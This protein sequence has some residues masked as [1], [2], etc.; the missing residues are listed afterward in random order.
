MKPE[1]RMF[2]LKDCI[3]NPAPK[4]EADTRKRAATDLTLASIFVPKLI[5][6]GIGG[7]ASLLKKAGA[8]ETEQVAAGEL[9]NLYVTDKDQQLLVNG[10]LGCILGVYGT[11][12]NADREPTPAD[13]AALKALEAKGL[14][15]AGADISIVFEAALV[16][17]SDGTAFF[18]EVRHFSVRDF[19]GDR[20]KPDRAYVATLSVTTPTSTADGSAIALGNVVLGRLK[21]EALP[22]PVK[23]PLG[24][25]PRYRSNLM[26]WQ[27]ITAEAK[28]AYESDVKRDAAKNKAYMPV[29]F[30]LTL[31]ETADGNKF[32]AALGELLE[33]AKA[34][35]AKELSSLVIPEERARAAQ[36]KTDAAE[37]LYQDEENAVIAVKEAKA[38]LDG[39]SADQKEVLTAKLDKAN[40]ALSLAVKLRK[41]AGLGDLSYPTADLRTQGSHDGRVGWTVGGKRARASMSRKQRMGRATK[42]DRRGRQAY[43]PS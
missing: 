17:T 12:A 36:D 21:E 1:F 11:F 34:D 3:V 28:D 20:R 24:T 43:K 38:A 4:P 25:Y 23:A 35:A 42:G 29:T 22:I 14:I 31:S 5:E 10:D 2:L 27:R 37:K 41:A 39:A 40:R 6:L 33:G 13:D 32:L 15:P 8:A 30:N 16:P 19:I 7:I 18:L 26:P 9:T